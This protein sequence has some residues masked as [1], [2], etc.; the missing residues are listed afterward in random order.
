[1]RRLVLR[2]VWLICIFDPLKTFAVGRR[3]IASVFA[4]N[5]VS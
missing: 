4:F 3:Y 2:A 5:F 1:V